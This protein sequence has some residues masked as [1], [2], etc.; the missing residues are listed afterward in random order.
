MKTF[1]PVV[2]TSPT[3]SA[4][5]CRGGGGDDDCDDDGDNYDDDDDYDCH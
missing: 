2:A 4:G 1:L 3:P 5:S